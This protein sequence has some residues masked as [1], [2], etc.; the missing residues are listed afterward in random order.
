M[1]KGLSTWGAVAIVLGFGVI[2]GGVSVSADNVLA[3]GVGAI[4]GVLGAAL[5]LRDITQSQSLLG[6]AEALDAAFARAQYAL[7]IVDSAGHTIAANTEGRRFWGDAD[8]ITALSVRVYESDADRE[9]MARLRGAY[10]A[11]L[12]ES[13]EISLQSLL[14]TQIGGRD[15]MNVSV[16][17]LA[18][19][20]GAQLLIAK[21]V[22][23]R[24]ALENVL[25]GESEY[26]SDFLDFLPVGVY[27]LD[28]EQNIHFVNQTLAEWLGESS[29]KLIGMPFAR[30][31]AKGTDMPEMD[32]AWCGE[33]RFQSTRT[34]PFPALLSHTLYDEGGETL[35]RAVVM[36][37]ATPKDAQN[38]NSLRDL[39]HFS[40]QVFEEAPVGI[41]VLDVEGLP[42]PMLAEANETLAMMLGR[43]KDDLIGLSLDDMVD[44]SMRGEVATVLE[45]AAQGLSV[46][47]LEVRLNCERDLTA[48]LHIRSL[49]GQEAS[50][51]GRGVAARQ[52]VH[53]VDTT[54]RRTLQMQTVQAQKMQA[55]GQLAGGV[56]H[57]F[58]NLLT[59]MIGFC[60][61][62]LQRHGPGSA[63]FTDIM[64]VKQ[65]AN[66]AANL[67]RQLLAFSRRQPLLPKF[68]SVSDAL[69]EMSHLLQR[70]LGEAIQFDLIHGRDVAFVRVDPGQFDQ[71][72][73]NLA[74]NARDAM[75][76]GGKLTIKT[77]LCEVK[78]L[79]KVG[80]ESVVPGE[81]A[82]ITVR[83]TGAGIDKD[84]L[85]RI[86]EP[87]FSTKESSAAAGTGLGLS[88]VYGIVR[89]TEGSVT[90]ESTKGEGTIFSLYFPHFDEAAVKARSESASTET[91]SSLEAK[92]EIANQPL[93]KEACLTMP[94]G[95]VVLLV[96][97]EDAVRV[98]GSRA[99]TAKGYT[100]REAS[101]GEEAIALL[102][103]QGEV[104]VLVTDMV[105]PGM[106]GATLARLV[107]QD[108]PS[109][110]VIL[111][112]GYSED[113]ASDDLADSPDILFLAK[114]FSLDALASRVA[115]T[116]SQREVQYDK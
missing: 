88:T 50:E 62:L 82:R 115:E 41:A 15:R 3:L 27:D 75:V 8:P 16:R 64:Q 116:L 91:A 90:V 59:A 38:E 86:F 54:D 65:N 80:T 9:A 33:V 19:P 74:V 5:I 30:V 43:S 36:R 56:A 103:D 24:R 52:L 20:Q 109:I 60:D 28:S 1:W 83:D 35:T 71:V 55:M 104:D 39:G 78:E 63:S 67:V 29:D 45:H 46:A 98:F 40:R 12:D 48:M 42:Y 25:K 10:D 57:D 32:G 17:A 72:V 93:E 92:Q 18:R 107:R 95:K 49:P 58:N 73:I 99:L 77:E 68:V 94:E 53:V 76:G 105:M 69:A 6:R 14:G 2:I 113:I 106:D 44:P 114:P 85:S 22:S 70:L 21:D 97:D 96:E 13:Q 102:K 4:L 7:R 100:V 23:A 31:L 47:P 81:Y 108:Y 111:M 37:D 110:R 51:G 26:L 87:F 84:V 79:L 112:S 61:L 101:N 89:Q 11:G 66:R 34:G